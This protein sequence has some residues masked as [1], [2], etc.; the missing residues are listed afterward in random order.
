MLKII[1]AISLIIFNI[2]GFVV[3]LID[4]RRELAAEK[5]EY[6]DNEPRDIGWPIYALIGALGGSLGILVAMFLKRFK[7][8]E[9]K[10]LVIMLGLLIL[11][12]ATALLVFFPGMF[13]ISAA[14]NVVKTLF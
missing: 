10:Y 14:D 1:F 7:L 2:A 11:N 4:R 3:V 6:S 5:G 8:D 13:F 12:I 9:A